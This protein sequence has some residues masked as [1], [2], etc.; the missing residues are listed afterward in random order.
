MFSRLKLRYL[1]V[2]LSIGSVFAETYHRIAQ[3]EEVTAVYQNEPDFDK[4]AWIFETINLYDAWEMGYSGRMIRFRINDDNWEEHVEWSSDRLIFNEENAK[5]EY[6]CGDPDNRFVKPD[7]EYALNHGAAVTSILGANGLND[8]CGTGIAPDSLIS[9]CNYKVNTTSPKVLMYDMVPLW[10]GF[11]WSDISM[12]GFAYEGCS[13]EPRK[14]GGMHRSK[15]ENGGKSSRRNLGPDEEIEACPFLKFYKDENNKGDNPCLV[16]TKSDFDSVGGSNKRDNIFDIASTMDDKAEDGDGNGDDDLAGVVS[17]ECA[18]SVRAYCL[19]NFRQDEALCTEWIEVI[20]DGNICQFKSNVD[21]EY[22]AL[23]RG[24]K[25]GRYG[26]GVIFVFAAGDSYGNGDNVNYQPYS[27]SRYVMTVGAVKLKEFPDGEDTILK[28][29]H[30][31]YSAAGTSVF[32]VAPGGDYD[33]PYK[34]IGAGRDTSG[35]ACVEYGH[36]TRFA[37]SVVGGVVALMLEANSGLTWRDVRAIIAET[38]KTIKIFDNKNNNDDATFEINAAG[39]GYSELYGFGLIDASAAVQMAE[40]WKSKG[41]HLPP[42]LGITA[43]SGVLNLGIVDD[44]FSTTTS[45]ITIEDNLFKNDYMEPVSETLESVSVYLKLRYFS[46]GHLRITVTSPSGT[47]SLLSPGGRHEYGQLKCGEWWEFLTLRNWGESPFGEWKLSITDTKQGV[48]GDVVCMDRPDFP[49]L[50]DPYYSL[51]FNFTV[52][53]EAYEAKGLCKNDKIKENDMRLKDD[54]FYDFLFEQEYGD[55]GMTAVSACC[56]CGGGIRPDDDEVLNDQLEEWKIVIGDGTP[57]VGTKR[58]ASYDPYLPEVSSYE[59]IRCSEDTFYGER[60]DCCNGLDAI[61]D[62]RVNEVLFAT[63]NN[64][65]NGYIGWSDNARFKKWDYVVDNKELEIERGLEAGYRAFKL[66]ICNCGGVLEFCFGGECNA[67]GVRDVIDVMRAFEQFLERNP[68]EIVIFFF[69]VRNDVDQYVDLNDFWF[70]FVQMW[71]IVE[72]VYV[73]DGGPDGKKK[74]WPTLRELVKMDQRLLLFHYNGPNCTETPKECPEKLHYY[75]D[76]VSDNNELLFRTPME[77]QNR[78]NSCD[79]QR[80]S[81]MEYSNTFVALTSFLIPEPDPS[82]RNWVYAR[83]TSEFLNQYS[84]VED[85]LE[86]CGEFFERDINFVLDDWWGEGEVLRITQDHNMGRALGESWIAPS[87]SPTVDPDEG[88]EEPTSF[89]TFYPTFDIKTFAPTTSVQPSGSPTE[90]PTTDDPCPR[91]DGNCQ[92]CKQ[93]IDECLWCYTS[94]S[95]YSREIFADIFDLDDEVLPCAGEDILNSFDTTCTASDNEF[96]SIYDD[97]FVG[98]DGN[99][100]IAPNPTQSPT[101]NSPSP[102]PTLPPIFV[103]ISPPTA[104]E[105]ADNFFDRYFGTDSGTSSLNIL[106][107]GIA[108]VL[109][110]LLLLRDA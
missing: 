15:I 76:Y 104:A 9:F 32:V 79:V 25:E 58:L 48:G 54:S 1:F 43:M 55:C 20:N 35:D 91:H 12:N 105:A 27:K 93:N 51:Q 6:S 19:R 77:I 33:S 103:P 38:S 29:I 84:M 68:S 13:S 23:N 2:C 10:L 90:L 108:A 92:G 18:S 47:T 100:T 22:L 102:P 3:E 45:T 99:E 17:E 80:A 67:N 87:P 11:G 59:F 98:D 62:L 94:L 30:S 60:G 37:A 65:M 31:T 26:K 41:K 34:H 46:R 63:L 7:D 50:D 89:P 64:G 40:K 95:C 71:D 85:Y 61:C 83:D 53:C 52:G 106:P 44:S 109:S 36:G 57:K 74:P 82:R 4:Q 66:D 56:I 96:K 72:K 78:T 86:S 97:D 42:E 16:C 101:E 70:L 28:P 73:H 14:N 75:Y 5:D 49:T 81:M 69:E 110:F 24:A 21:H 8:F 39:V 107:C 88:L